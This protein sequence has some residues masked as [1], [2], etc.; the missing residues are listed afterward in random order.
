MQKQSQLEIFCG[1]GGVGKTTLSCAR[2]LY[3][4]KL[5]KTVLL[6]TIDPSQRLKDFFQ[7]EVIHDSNVAE[8]KITTLWQGKQFDL[9]LF[10]PE[11]TYQHIVTRQHKNILFEQ[12]H[13]LKMIFRREGGMNEVMALLEL[14]EQIKLGIYDV[15]ILDTAPG[16]HFIDFLINCEKIK[17]F[18]NQT[19]MEII[20]SFSKKNDAN[21]SSSPLASKQRFS[22][23]KPFETMM[24]KVV[25]NSLSKLLR[26]LN[27]L[28]GEG[29]VHIFVNSV[30]QI[31]LLKNDFI[32]SLNLI[33]YIQNKEQSHWF[34]VLSAEQ[35]KKEL[36][37]KM[38]AQIKKMIQ[39]DAHIVV[40]K[41]WLKY[42]EQ[43]E[44]ES[45]SYQLPNEVLKQ[46]FEEF[47][48]WQK[49]ISQREK[50]LISD[51]KNLFKKMILFPE[52]V[53]SDLQTQIEEL[54]NDWMLLGPLDGLHKEENKMRS[55]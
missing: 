42:W 13:I 25:E 23:K 24:K 9:M 2:A 21:D 38:Y 27:M 53:S 48:Q 37:L 54:M 49:L 4:A 36:A 39:H 34:L 16:Q 35:S 33:P 19:F 6:M 46:E 52:V 29:F 10:S 55:Q 40:N 3:H 31:Y 15:I 45:S 11:R 1:T 7:H 8:R 14:H 47:K 41:S 26:Y 5:D 12:N 30:E 44:K 22:F 51:L 32:D 43:W 17:R 20:F 50:I 28:T 18:F